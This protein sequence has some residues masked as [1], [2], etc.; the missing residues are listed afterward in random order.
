MKVD[1]QENI[2]VVTREE[3][4]PK[5]YG[6]VNAAGES[7]LFHHIKLKLKEAGHKVIKKRM[8]KDGHMVDDMQQYIRTVKGYEPS[9]AIYNSQWAIAGAEVEYNANGHVTLSVI[10][11]LW[12]KEREVY[13][14]PKCGWESFDPD[15]YEAECGQTD[16]D[17]K[18]TETRTEEYEE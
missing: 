10:R 1:L 14:C 5:F 4:D 16:C 7:K 2:C 12:S 13:S 3:G 8:H 15:Q 17:G 6:V 9:F 18:L 11:N